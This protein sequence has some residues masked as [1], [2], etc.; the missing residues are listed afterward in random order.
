[1]NEVALSDD[2]NVITAE[3]NSYKQVAGQAIFE[4]GK[5]LKHVKEN[6]LVH[7]EFGKWLEGI[8]MTHQHANRYMKVVDELGDTNYTSM[9][10]LGVSALYQIATMPEDE[11]EKKHD[12]PNGETKTVDEMTLRELEELKRQIKQE[13]K[14]KQQ[15]ETQAEQAR[16]SEQIMQKQ[17]EEMENQGPEQIEV[18]PDDYDYYKGN[19]KAAI[20]MRDQY[21]QQMEEMREELNNKEP[22]VKEV[23]PEAT[24]E[25]LS[26]LERVVESQKQAFEEAKKELESYRMKDADEYDEE[27]A[28]KELK[29]LQWEA[30]KSIYRFI[31]KVDDFTKEISVFGYMEGE[32][33][34]SS[35][36]TK[37]RLKESIDVLKNFTKKMETSLKGR[38]EI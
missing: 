2:L 15:A 13:K 24:K 34:S 25:R 5:R 32:I 14:D 7:G 3:I 6:D 28:E 31:N 27:Q 36:K 38:I 35:D 1:M 18:V 21:K 17:L 8:G 16:R 11:R 33:A 20:D 29:K 10:N 37:E 19:Y 4:I 30:E 22:E 9:F 23:V 26:Q 12:L